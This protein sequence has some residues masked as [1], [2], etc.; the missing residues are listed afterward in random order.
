MPQDPNDEAASGLL[1]RIRATRAAAD[2]KQ[3]RKVRT[4][5]NPIMTTLTTDTLKE[6][7]RGLPTDQFTFDDLRGQVSADYETLK[8]MIFVL[9][10]EAPAS[11]QVFDTEAKGSQK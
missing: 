6:I 1:E 3:A 4:E 10:S 11:I 9:L 8:D 2:G 7:I 5:R